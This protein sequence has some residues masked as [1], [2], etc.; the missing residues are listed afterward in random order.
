MAA[1]DLDSA[2]AAV[3]DALP[4]GWRSIAA[5]AVLSALAVVGGVAGCIPRHPPDLA[6]GECVEVAFGYA[7]E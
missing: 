5:V 7:L 1:D 6:T 3:F 4:A 2:W